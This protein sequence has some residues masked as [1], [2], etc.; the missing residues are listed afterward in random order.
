VKTPEGGEE[1]EER[2]EG[3]HGGAGGGDHIESVKTRTA[4]SQKEEESGPSASNRCR[5]GKEHS[6]LHRMPTLR[7]PT[8]MQN[9]QERRPTQPKGEPGED[10]PEERHAQDASFHDDEAEVPRDTVEVTDLVAVRG[11]DGQ[12]DPEEEDDDGPIA[13]WG[14]GG[15][16]SV[17][18]GAEEERM[19]IGA[20]QGKEER[21]ESG[22]RGLGVGGEQEHEPEKEKEKSSRRQGKL[23][24]RREKGQSRRR[25]TRRGR[26]GTGEER[27]PSMEQESGDS[28]RGSM[29]LTDSASPVLI[30]VDRYR[31]SLRPFSLIFTQSESTYESGPYVQFDVSV[32]DP[33]SISIHHPTED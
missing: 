4:P 21:R 30:I 27:K 24:Q 9:T 2:H 15:G 29:I 7:S 17:R 26:R 3:G 23:G 8:T 20:E 19:A 10:V 32:S 16:V 22:S 5:V 25:S 33:S 14:G 6:R 11:E 31:F 18:V 12:E 28:P 1:G 13:C